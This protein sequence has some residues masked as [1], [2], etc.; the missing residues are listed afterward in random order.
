V[1]L[2]GTVRRYEASKRR[3]FGCEIWRLI[4]CMS[5]CLIMQGASKVYVA[6]EVV[7]RIK[8]VYFLIITLQ[9]R[10]L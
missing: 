1:D 3:E 9:E 8:S 10:S 2:L 4:Y 6:T 5:Q 7:K